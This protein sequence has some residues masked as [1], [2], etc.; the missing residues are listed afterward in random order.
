MATRRQR[1][2]EPDCPGLILVDDD[3]VIRETLGFVLSDDFTVYAATNRPEARAFGQGNSA[4]LALVDLGLPPQPH[5]PDEGLAL[6]SELLLDNPTMKVLIL[7]GQT[8]RDHIQHALSLGAVDFVP[9]PCDTQLL[10]ARLRHQLMLRDAELALP[11]QVRVASR[12][13][14]DSRAMR[15]LRADVSRYA[16]TD[17]AVLIEGESGSGKELVAELLHEQSARASQPF[18]TVNCAAFNRELLEAQ[19]F[20]HARGAFTGAANVRTG[21]FEDADNGTLFLDEI[22]ELPLDLQPKLLRVLENG[23]YYRLA[24]TRPRYANVRIIAATNRNL[25][26][27]S[28]AGRFRNDLYHRL[29]VL[30][31]RVPSLHVRYRQP[32]ALGA[33]SRALPRKNP[34]VHSRRRRT[35]T[36]ARVFVPG[37]CARAT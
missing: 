17:F 19:L 29:R 16:N 26:E 2:A 13:V 31:V 34:T 6:T 4:P 33:F 15:D 36:L 14:G 37:Q 11:A 21:F 18:L 10:K 35:R 30:T 1:P 24:E 22:G 12:L 27:E 23:Q 9:K 20:G 32:P 7:F 25:A 28:R 5:R 3:P 8:T